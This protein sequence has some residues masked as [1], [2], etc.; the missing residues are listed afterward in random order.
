LFVITDLA[1][2]YITTIDSTQIK[3]KGSILY[4]KNQ[5]SRKV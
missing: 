4:G 5:S 1:G 2:P 3:S